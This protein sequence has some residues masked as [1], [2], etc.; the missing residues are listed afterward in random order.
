MNNIKKNQVMM[1]I[2]ALLFVFC[3]QAFGRLFGI[4]YLFLDPEYLDK[5]NW[6]SLAIMG[7]SFGAFSMSFQITNYI[8]DSSRFSFLATLRKPFGKFVINNSIIPLAFLIT[9]LVAFFKF[10]TKSGFK[11]TDEII[12][13]AVAFV[14]AFLSIHVL[15]YFYFIFT[16]KDIFK[17][18]AQKIDKTISHTQVSKVNVMKQFKVNPF[19]KKTRVDYYYDLPFKWVK[20][21]KTKVY[22]KE[23]ISKVFDQNHL[24]AAII[25]LIGFVSILVLS[26]FKDNVYFQ[27]PA[28]ASA[29][30]LFSFF[31]MVTG[32][33][34]YWFRGWAITGVI[35][36][37]FC[38]NHIVKN[39]LFDTT[40][41]AYGINYNGKKAQYD[42]N[43]VYSLSS[44]KNFLKDVDSTMLILEN[45]RAK[46]PK[47]K[48]PKMVFVCVSGGGQRAAVW[49][50]RSLQ[51]L[52]TVSKGKLM[53]QTMLITGASGGM[54]GAAFYREYY[55]R[56]KQ[57]ILGVPL[58]SEKLFNNMSKDVLNPVAFSLVVNDLF[59]RSQNF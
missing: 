19:K 53:N 40:Y 9:Y 4:P 58:H 16:N 56:N 2:W 47:E 14:L 57:G 3:T 33:F 51:V 31:I 39:D 26:F 44:D 28:G 49:A 7:F 34:S 24:N 18:L 6:V 38:L 22:D 1:F 36:L 42:L 41:K 30:I 59:F 43:R 37:F 50:L 12:I 10:Q 20:I 52:D 46:F 17:L 23:F 35:F 54:V 25:Q 8:L 11:S 21:D 45:W 48:K 15:M 13:Q 32:F 5:V 55:L 27:I 29:M